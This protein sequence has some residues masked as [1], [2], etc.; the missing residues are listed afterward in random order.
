MHFWQTVEASLSV[1]KNHSRDELAV[2]RLGDEVTHLATQLDENSREKLLQQSEINRYVY[3][4]IID[5][6]SNIILY[7]YYI[8]YV[9]VCCYLLLGR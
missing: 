3:N 6:S 9:S 8:N 7:M 2:R 5:I 4:F 1:A